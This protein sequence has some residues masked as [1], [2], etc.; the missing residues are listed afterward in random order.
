MKTD[1]K[2]KYITSYIL[3]LDKNIT[4]TIENKKKMNK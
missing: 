2:K 4:F 1:T 3:S